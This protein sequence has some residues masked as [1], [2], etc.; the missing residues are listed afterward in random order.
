MPELAM[1]PL[2]TVLLPHMVLPLHV[3]EPRYRAMMDDILL[4][5]REFGVV[6]ITHGHEV[7]GDDVRSDVGT[8]ARVMHAEELDDGRWLV[9]ALGVRRLRVDRWLRDDPY[10]RAL[11]T[12]LEEQH[13]DAVVLQRADELA[14]RLRA[15]LRKQRELGDDPDPPVYEVSPDLDIACWQ[16]AVIAP[17]NPFDAQRVLAIDD[18]GERLTF[19]DELLD[20]IDDALTFR[21]GTDAE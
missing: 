2:G 6:L 8:V 21:L 16:P 1:F 4:G 7:G 12:D 10:P 5:D 17:I 3:F 15:I 13:D 20:G 18:C 9:V 11:V 14:P 19:L